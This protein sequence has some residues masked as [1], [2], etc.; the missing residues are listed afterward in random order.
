MEMNASRANTVQKMREELVLVGVAWRSLTI[1]SKTILRRESDATITRMK[2]MGTKSDSANDRYHEVL[3]DLCYIA[4]VREEKKNEPCETHVKLR[5][6]F[7]QSGKV[8]CCAYTF[9]RGG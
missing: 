6:Q 1:E 9:C 8:A 2:L 7:D 5:A 3:A 4:E